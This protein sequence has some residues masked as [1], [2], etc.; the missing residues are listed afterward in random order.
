[1]SDKLLLFIALLLVIAS[2][3]LDHWTAL[4][5]LIPVALC[6]L[7]VHRRD[8]ARVHA[9]LEKRAAAQQRMRDELNRRDEQ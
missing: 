4:L 8:R 3:A 6:I 5:L 9:Q 1:M 7:T 2:L